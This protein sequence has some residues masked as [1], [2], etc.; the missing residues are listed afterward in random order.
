[1]KPPWTDERRPAPPRREL[2]REL[3]AA[4]GALVRRGRPRGRRAPSP[5]G[6]SELPE[7]AA[8]AHGGGVRL[9]RH[10]NPA[11]ARCSTR[12]AR[13]GVRVLLPVL[14]P[15]NDLDWARVRG[16]GRLAGSR[17]AGRCG[18]WSPTGRAAR[19]GRRDR[20]PTPCCCPG[21]A[22]DARGMRLG[23]GGGS[24][25]RVLARLERAGRRSRRW[26]CSCTTTRWSR[27]SRRNRTTTPCTRWSTP[28]G[29]RR[30]RRPERAASTRAWRPLV[31]RR[32]ASASACR[33][34]RRRPP[35]SPKD[36]SSSSPLAHLSVWSV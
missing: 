31:S 22:V 19:P 10:A 21:L 24:Y 14:L 23:R 1:M 11:P 30:F 15:D 20:R 27:G 26:W 4:R 36:Q 2:R 32:S 18:C 6:R 34:C 3:L 8:R 17:T 28:S 7:L 12:C 25:D 9:R 33:S 35:R 29:V 13:A 16:R 5:A